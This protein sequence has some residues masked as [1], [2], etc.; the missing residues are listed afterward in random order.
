VISAQDRVAASRMA[1]EYGNIILLDDGFQYRQLQR[2]CDIVLIPNEGFGN[3]YILPAGPLREPPKALN[4]ADI[5]VRT[6]TTS[7]K[8]LTTTKEWHWHSKPQPLNDWN[9]CA[10]ETP[11]SVAVV[12]A[13]ARP[14]RFKESLQELDVQIETSYFF[15][16]HHAFTKQD[17]Y[18][19]W[20]QSTAIAVTAKDAVKLLPL[21]PKNK[22]LWVLEQSFEG[23]VG[24]IEAVLESLGKS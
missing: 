2:Q 6:G 17:M 7:N 15:P 18:D 13:I 20:Q 5:I 16:D 10:K 8:P 1:A 12:S 4:R 22:P 3:G 9:Q 24:L 19:I 11:K 23:E 21:W 14:Q